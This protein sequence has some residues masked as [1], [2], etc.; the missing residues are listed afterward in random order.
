MKNENCN[1][2]NPFITIFTLLGIVAGFVLYIIL[3]QDKE[4]SDKKAKG[5]SKKVGREEKSIKNLNK[6]KKG[7]KSKSVKELSERQKRIVV[8]LEK[9]G[10]IFPSQLQELLPNVS[11]RTVRRDMADLEKKNIV[12]QKGSTKSTYYI[13]IK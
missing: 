10:K 13:Y 7:E 6:S 9:E 3:K 1:T 8:L 5:S 12:E 11:T 2:P 4:D